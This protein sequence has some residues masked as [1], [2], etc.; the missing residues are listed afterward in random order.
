MLPHCM[1]GVT[2]IYQEDLS[3]VPKEAHWHIYTPL[4]NI[5]MITA[6]QKIAGTEQYVEA[7]IAHAL[8][9]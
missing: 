1:H 2:S 6:W 9:L 3:W 5:Q 7:H 4:Q 8:L